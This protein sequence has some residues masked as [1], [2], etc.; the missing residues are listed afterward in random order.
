MPKCGICWGGPQTAMH[1]GRGK[2]R[3]VREKGHPRRKKGEEITFP[4][5]VREPLNFFKGSSP[6]GPAD[7]PL[8]EIL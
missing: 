4:E 8:R 1:Y 7:P 2:M 6:L 3:S 5:P